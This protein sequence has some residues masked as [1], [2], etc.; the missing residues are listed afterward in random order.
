MADAKQKGE[1]VGTAFGGLLFIIL[2]TSGIKGGYNTF[3]GEQEGLVK[4]DDCRRMVT[5]KE[6]S[7]E[8]WF[9]KF[10]CTYRKTQK[11]IVMSGTCVAIDTEGAA[12]Q[13]AYMYEKKVSNGGCNDPK[14]PYLGEDDL[15]YPTP[16]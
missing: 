15:C 8:T 13:T 14:H 11:G 2:V 9:K 5:V 1:K 12:C 4:T 6:D 16:H 3:W 7:P 10:T